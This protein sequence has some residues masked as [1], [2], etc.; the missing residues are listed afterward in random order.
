MRRVCVF[1]GSS[2]GAKREYS[3][4]ARRLGELLAAEDITLVYGGGNIG[5][6]GILADSV[7]D[8]GGSVIGVIPQQLVQRELAHKGIS[9]LRIVE[10]MHERKQEMSEMAD[11]FIAL[12][13]GIGTLEETFEILTWAQLGIHR[14]AVGILNVGGYYDH[15]RILL[16]H[17]VRERFIK[18]THLKSL[19]IDRDERRLLSRVKA[20]KIPAMQQWLNSSKT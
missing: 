20:C 11:A 16:D 1:C 19:I 10:S 2:K 7:M 14:K 4:A 8:N 9:E 13:G 12:P 18:R 5:L 15:M 17:M 6:M 3:Q